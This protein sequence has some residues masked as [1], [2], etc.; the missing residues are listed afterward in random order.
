MTLEEDIFQKTKINY[1][2]LISYGFH[3][4]SHQY[5]YV[6]DIFDIHFK[7]SLLFKTMIVYK[8]IS[9]I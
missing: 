9:L 3:K 5:I 6:Q 1:D 8:D 2:K 4:Q 7:L